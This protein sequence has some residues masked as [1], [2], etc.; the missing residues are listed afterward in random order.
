MTKKSKNTFLHNIDANSHTRKND[1]MMF[2]ESVDS[3]EV[4]LAV[5]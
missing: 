2:F 1:A 4:T 3:L 5:C